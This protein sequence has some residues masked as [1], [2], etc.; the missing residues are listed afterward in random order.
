MVSPCRGIY[1]VGE[2]RKLWEQTRSHG[3][4][5]VTFD[6]DNEIKEGSAVRT[7]SNPIYAAGSLALNFAGGQLM[8]R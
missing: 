5:H 3:K 8:V 6:V 7:K 1:P 4:K 2:R